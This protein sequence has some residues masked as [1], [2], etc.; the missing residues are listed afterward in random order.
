MNLQWSTYLWQ[1]GG[2]IIDAEQSSVLYNSEA[3]IQAL[4]FWKDLFHRMGSPA[5]SITH[6]LSFVSQNVSMIMDG[7]WDL[8]RFREIENF[9]WGIAP[10][11]AGPAGQVTYIAGEH[12]AIFRQSRNPEAAWTFVKWVTQPEIQAMFSEDSGYLP[13]RLST[14]DLPEYREALARDERL[15][16]FVEQIPIGRVRRPLDFYQVEINRHIAEAIERTLIGGIDARR[17]LS[18]SARKS[19]ELLKTAAL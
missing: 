2:D 11:P 6:D 18:E 13:V 7:P 19:N 15:R 17:A 16:A 14:L 4:A 8:P 1:A 5:N 9:D 3:G 10:L 12:L